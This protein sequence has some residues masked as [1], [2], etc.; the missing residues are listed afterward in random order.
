MRLGRP[1]KSVHLYLAYPDLAYPE[2]LGKLKGS[3]IDTIGGP[4]AWNGRQVYMSV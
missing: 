3:L 4:L 1:A 2:Y